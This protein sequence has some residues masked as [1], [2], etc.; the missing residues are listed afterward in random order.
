MAQN[1]AKT[2]QAPDSRPSDYIDVNREI[3]EA[4]T[5]LLKIVDDYWQ[6]AGLGEPV[7]VINQLLYY[8]LT[9]SSTDLS[10]M[11]NRDQLHT[12]HVLISFLTHLF[13]TSSLVDYLKKGGVES[14][15]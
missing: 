7:E 4:Q 3:Y 5:R 6:D 2:S 10:L 1:V 8:W 9:T 14:G 11:A 12:A 15:K 13:E